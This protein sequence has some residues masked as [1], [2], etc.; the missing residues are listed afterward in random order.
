MRISGEAAGR[1]SA[2]SVG[3]PRARFALPPALRN[4]VAPLAL[5]LGWRALGLLVAIVAS[6]FGGT[7]PPATLGDAV[8]RGLDHWDAGWYLAIARDGYALPS[9][10]GQQANVAFYPLLP[11][12]IRLVHLAIPSWRLAGMLVVHV[13]LAGAVLYL[14]ALVRLDHDRRTGLRA[15]VALLLYPTAI[16]LTAIYTESLLLLG[17]L[18]AVYHARRGQWWAAGLWGLLAGLTKTIGVVALVPLAWEYWRAAPWR[19]ASPAQR[20]GQLV[21]L[22]LVPLGTVA[23]L[24]YLQVHF[25]SYQ[26]Y[27]ATQ[28][29]WFREGFFQPFLTD[30]WGFLRAFLRGEGAGVTNYFY[31][32]GRT[33]LPSAGAFMLLDLGFLLVAFG[34]GLLV[35]FRLRVSYGLL[36][37]A[38]VFLTAYSGSPQSFNRYTLILFPLPIAFAVAGRRP[39]I[40][41]ALL[42]LSGLLSLYHAYLFVNGF[43]AG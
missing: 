30:G 7:G 36:V 3:R 16:F 28:V 5:L 8:T 6:Q 34:V 24:G 4:A 22:A 41:F 25:G 35:T 43:W 19:G 40:G 11:L 13:A 33:T 42:T 37:L 39:A 20:A 31:P 15:V 2:A 10:P 17:L 27:F 32:Q 23:Y 26:V 14:D 21:A 1:A 18:G 38:G 29:V 9:G 12:L